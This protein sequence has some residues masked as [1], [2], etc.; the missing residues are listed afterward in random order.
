MLLGENMN[1]KLKNE[2]TML[3]F[4]AMLT[5]ENTDECINL[6][7]DLCTIAEIK[8]MTQRLSV[9][10]LLKSGMSYSD[11]A[12]QTGASSATISR[13]NRCLNYGSNGYNTVIERLKK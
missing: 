5:L 11:I 9:A 7:D 1:E 13:V 10:L 12:K 6:F 2:E 4:E 3:L 8:A